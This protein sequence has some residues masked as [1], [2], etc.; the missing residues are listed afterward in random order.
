MI[1]TW[2]MVER[3]G[4]G[5]PTL[6]LPLDPWEEPFDVELDGSPL[7]RQL[8][9]QMQDSP[10]DEATA[11]FAALAAHEAGVRGLHERVAAYLDEHGYPPAQPWDEFDEGDDWRDLRW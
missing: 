1:S 2:R 3:H 7:L 9:R 10:S 6:A 4:P 11:L 5:G 8:H